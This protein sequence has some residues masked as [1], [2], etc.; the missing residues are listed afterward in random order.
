MRSRYLRYALYF[1]LLTVASCI[2]ESLSWQIEKVQWIHGSA[3]CKQNTDPPIQVVQC[4]SNTW[5]LR[6][7]KCL[8]YEAPFVFVLC[9]ETNAL[10]IDTGATEDSVSFPLHHVIDSLMHKFYLERYSK[11]ELVVAHTHAHG[12]HHAADSQFV[13][14][15]R[16]KVVGLR[17]SEVKSFFKISDWPIQI[18]KFDLGKREIDLIPIPGHEETSLAF[19]DRETG[20]LFSGD[21]FYPGRLYVRDWQAFRL[22]IRRLL[23]FSKTHSIKNFVGNHIEMTDVAGKDYPIGTAFQPAEHSLPL[24]V[25]DLHK[26]NDELEKLGDS[27]KLVTMD[28]F[29]IYPVDAPLTKEI[30]INETAIATL[31]ID[32]YPDFMKAD[33]DGVWVTNV[34]RIEKLKFGAQKPALSVSIPS[35]CG[36]MATGFGSLW[37]ADCKSESVYRVD[38]KSGKVQSIIKTGLADREGELSIAASEDAVWLLTKAAGE[39]ARIDPKTNKVVARIDVLTNSFAVTYGNHG[40]WITNTKNAS[41]QKVD[42]KSNKVVSPIKVGK[43][44]RFLAVGFNAV[45][46][47]NQE[48]G[49]VSKIE[50]TTNE[51]TTI[52][53][54]VKGSGGDITT[55]SKYVYVRAKKT[56]LSVIDPE[57]NKV[58]QRFGP[59]AGSGAVAVENGRVWITAHDINKVW[60]LKE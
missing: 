60:V 16:V 14:K 1:L 55:G 10:L 29:I 19:F 44:P 30:N 51:V 21:T 42:P 43:E 33:A 58:I 40:L 8:N 7:N 35:P 32:G 6:Q 18:Q 50:A 34:G 5:I 37:V 12:D 26:L 31:T 59:T 54:N 56:L 25:N 17:L 24:S 22:S 3:D 27:A 39:L 47:L 11:I 2:R 46:T 36:V 15:P 4:N 13:G 41:V 38:L 28:D 52:D 49:T 53:V 23:N 9:G 20:F 48:D 45:W 57:T